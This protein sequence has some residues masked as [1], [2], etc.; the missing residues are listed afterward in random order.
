MEFEKI[1]KSL[2]DEFRDEICKMIEA[3]LRSDPQCPPYILAGLDVAKAVKG[4]HNTALELVE[5]CHV[6]VEAE[7][8]V[9]IR[10]IEQYAR[11]VTEGI[12]QYVLTVRAGGTP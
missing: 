11:L 3:D 12:K 4:L 9:V 7:N 10:E 2:H 6:F 5:L 8:E 1:P